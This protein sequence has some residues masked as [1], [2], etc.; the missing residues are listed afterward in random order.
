MSTDNTFLAE[1]TT[2]LTALSASELAEKIHSRE[3]SSV[4]ATQAHLDRI[5]EVDSELGAFLHV[6]A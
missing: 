5:S 3:V 6:G 1:S 4:E 2:G